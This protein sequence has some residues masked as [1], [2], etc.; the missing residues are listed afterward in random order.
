MIL[1]R[2]LGWL[3]ALPVTLVGLAVFAFLGPH[4]FRWRRLGYHGAGWILEC[5]VRR[6]PGGFAAITFGVL[7][8]Y[9]IA[10]T[11]QLR[12]HEDVHVLQGFLFGPLDLV[13]YGAC[14]GALF[15]WSLAAGRDERGD[16]AP[17]AG[18]R[19]RL[20]AAWRAAYRRHP[21]ERWAYAWQ[22]RR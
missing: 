15:V 7:Q 16:V 13:I 4:D 18:A 12:A 9:R 20:R 6:N 2:A 17:E 21:L 14:F 5:N 11:N 1:L 10:A 19:E 3:W 22:E 8:G